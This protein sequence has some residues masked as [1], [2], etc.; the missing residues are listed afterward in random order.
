MLTYVRC[1]WAL[2]AISWLTQQADLEQE[3]EDLAAAMRVSLAEAEQRAAAP[4]L[5]E[6]PDAQ[7]LQHF[8]TSE[9]LPQV[10]TCYP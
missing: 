6:W 2:A 4:P 8:A 9:L 1:R 5:H 10:Q 3:R 7:L